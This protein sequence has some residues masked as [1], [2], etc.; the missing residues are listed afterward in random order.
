M[1][2]RTS[3]V[4]RW[5]H[6]P[7]MPERCQSYRLKGGECKQICGSFVSRCH[8]NPKRKR[9]RSGRK[10][11]RLRIGFVRHWETQRLQAKAQGSWLPRGPGRTLPV[12]RA[13]RG[14]TW[15]VFTRIL[16]QTNQAGRF[17]RAGWFESARR[18]APPCSLATETVKTERGRFGSVLRSARESPENRA[19]ESRKSRKSRTECGKTRG[20]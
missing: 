3:N 16:N 10:F 5:S 18:N 15:K 2:P 7:A 12:R 6:L 17:G 9:G 20:I 11:P 4:E 14:L 1:D 8:T 13:N 19:G